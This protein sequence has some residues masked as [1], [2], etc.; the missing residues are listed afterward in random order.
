MIGEESRRVSSYMDDYIDT[1]IIPEIVHVVRGREYAPSQHIKL[2]DGDTLVK[3][4]VLCKNPAGEI[5][6]YDFVEG[7]FFKERE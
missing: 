7:R 6:Y 1:G 5:G 2:Y 3:D 4:L